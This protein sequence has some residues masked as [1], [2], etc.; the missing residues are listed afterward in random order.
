M[1]KDHFTSFSGRSAGLALET[2]SL[3]RE[4]DFPKHFICFMISCCIIFFGKNH[5]KLYQRYLLE[6]NSFA[7]TS[8]FGL[9]WG[10]VWRGGAVLKI[11]G[12]GAVRGSYFHR[13]GA[14]IPAKSHLNL[15]I[16]VSK[17]VPLDLK[18]RLNP[19]LEGRC[20]EPY[21]TP[22]LSRVWG[23]G[24]RTKIVDRSL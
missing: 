7:L 15:K 6:K 3:H 20:P 18:G 21:H 2:K 24:D 13:G 17:F 23:L 12:A 4:C 8:Y 16:L 1:T 9:W 11:F 10:V 14:C 19:D 22:L 5:T